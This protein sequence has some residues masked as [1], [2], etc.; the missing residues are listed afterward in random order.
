MG[1]PSGRESVAT[2]A[3]VVCGSLHPHTITTRTRKKD[4]KNEG[5]SGYVYENK[6]KYDIMPDENSAFSA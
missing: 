1:G 2:T 6:V 5:C 3:S 4:V